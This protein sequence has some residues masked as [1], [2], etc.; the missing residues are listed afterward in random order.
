MNVKIINSQEELEQYKQWTHYEIWRGNGMDFE[1]YN[2]AHSLLVEEYKNCINISYNR[3]DDNKKIAFENIYNAVFMSDTTSRF[4]MMDNLAILTDKSKDDIEK[5]YK[6]FLDLQDEKHLYNC[7]AKTQIPVYTNFFN[8]E[9]IETKGSIRLSTQDPS[10]N[11]LIINCDLKLQDGAILDVYGNLEAKNIQG[12]F[13]GVAGN[14]KANEIVC[15]KLF[16]Y[17]VDA[18]SITCYKKD[19]TFSWSNALTIDADIYSALDNTFDVEFLQPSHQFGKM[20][21][22]IIGKYEF[23]EA[24]N[25]ENPRFTSQCLINGNVEQISFFLD[26]YNIFNAGNLKAHSIKTHNMVCGDIQVDNL[27]C[28]TVLNASTM[29]DEV[30]TIRYYSESNYASL[31]YEELSPDEQLYYPEMKYICKIPPKTRLDFSNIITNTLVADS[32]FANNFKG[33]YCLANDRF[34]CTGNVSSNHIKSNILIGQNIEADYLHSNKI[35]SHFVESNVLKIEECLNSDYTS[36]NYRF[37][38]ADGAVLE[39]TFSLAPNLLQNNDKLNT[40]TEV[41]AKPKHTNRNIENE[42]LFNIE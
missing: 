29:Y 13:L 2:K 37:D 6:A 26:K 36:V 31:N 30:K 1:K 3:S 38:Y 22:I 25:L 32:I 17:D 4:M 39:S 35:Y 40:I 18:D 23:Q 33:D 12:G 42:K 15:E 9:F 28:N 24:D 20:N 10:D 21:D 34:C 7:Y 16:A 8:E 41:K 19:I 14:L 11:K 5:E 27:T